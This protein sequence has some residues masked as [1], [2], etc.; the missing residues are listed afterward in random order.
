M[1][2][3]YFHLSYE[4]RKSIEDGLNENIS[5]NQIAVE[6]GRSHSTILREVD[7]NKIYYNPINTELYQMFKNPTFDSHC[8]KLNNHLMFA[9]DANREEVV[10]KKGIHTMLEKHMILM[11]KLKV[12]QE[13]ELT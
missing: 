4:D 5:I 11:L 2:N 8:I 3:N 7:R 12:R 1:A 13:K 9:M 6:L 10:E